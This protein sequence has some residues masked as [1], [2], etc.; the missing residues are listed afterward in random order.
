VVVGYEDAH[1]ASIVHRVNGIEP[2]G[3]PASYL[4]L[5]EGT[6]V[7]SSDGEEVGKVAHVLA[8]EEDDIFDGIVIDPSWLPGG[9]VFADAAEVQEI[10]SDAV[11]LKLD[12]ERSRSLPQPSDNPAA[13]EVG[14]DD[15]AKEDLGDETKDKLRRAWDRI[16]GNY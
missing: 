15:M 4:T 1:R 3:D 9:H 13:M 10:R 11:T 2:A 5:E 12:A 8:V 14:P 7:F 16:S 6:K